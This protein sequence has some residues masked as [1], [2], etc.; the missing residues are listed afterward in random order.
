MQT[1][2]TIRANRTVAAAGNQF[3]QKD[4]DGRSSGQAALEGTPRSVDNKHAPY[5]DP[6]GSSSLLLLESQVRRAKNQVPET[7][8]ESSKRP[9][10]VQRWLS[11]NQDYPEYWHSHGGSEEASIVKS[12]EDRE[13][14]D[15]DRQRRYKELNEY[16]QGPDN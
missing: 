14:E 2:I 7:R 11:Q 5:S 9:V 4:A 16:P 6:T 8:G 15:E 3:D 13:N 12:V 10:A 1:D